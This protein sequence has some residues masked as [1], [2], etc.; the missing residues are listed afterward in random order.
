[1][2]PTGNAIADRINS[3]TPFIAAPEEDDSAWQAVQGDIRETYYSRSPW[4]DIE[5]YEKGFVVTNLVTGCRHPFARWDDA[6]QRRQELAN[7]YTAIHR[8]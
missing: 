6:K 5:A 2:I 1:M 3:S 7:R 4:A 8:A